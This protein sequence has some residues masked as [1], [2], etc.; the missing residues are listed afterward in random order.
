MLR[1]IF[2]TFFLI[3]VLSCRGQNKD[4]FYENTFNLKN[5]F[6]SYNS[7]I[8]IIKDNISVKRNLYKSVFKRDS[9]ETVSVLEWL[10]SIY[11]TDIFSNVLKVNQLEFSY[12]SIIKQKE[13]DFKE[14]V[15]VG[16]FK[17]QEWVFKTE[18]E[19][20][21]AYSY[22]IKFDKRYFKVNLN[23][24]WLKKSNLIYFLDS[25][26]FD[27]DSK[28]FKEVFEVTKKALDL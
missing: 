17:I 18:T 9:T 3:F 5:E 26:S 22:L 4:V 25:E 1:I 15:F 23:R 10:N 16:N 27:T 13:T 2:L 24:V 8:T 20:S 6:I 11:D 28:E 14:E 12:G 21:D 19:A 7:N